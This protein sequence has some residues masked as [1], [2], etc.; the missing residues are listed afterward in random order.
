MNDHAR[1]VLVAEGGNAGR[2]QGERFRRDGI[3][4]EPAGAENAQDVAV[5]EKRNV[6]F[7]GERAF[8]HFTGS[9]RYLADGLSAGHAVAK[10]R[11]SR[12]FPLDL[13]GGQ[14]FVRAIVPFRQPRVRLRHPAETSQFTRLRCALQRTREHQCERMSGEEPAHRD[15]ALNAIRSQRN[16][17]ASGM[18][19]GDAPF[20]FAVADQPDFAR[21][22]IYLRADVPLN[23]NSSPSDMIGGMTDYRTR[24]AGP[25]DLDLICHHRERMFREARSAE[26][27]LAPMTAHFRL[28]LEPRL[29][30]GSYS[31]WIVEHE[32]KAVAGTGLIVLDWPPHPRHPFASRRGYILN[33]FVEPEHRGRGIA[34]SLMKRAAHEA[35][36]RGIPFL[37][38]HATDAGRPVYEKLGW[39]P[40][41]EMSLSTL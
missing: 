4:P 31:G 29:G 24:P 30:D 1:F 13:A 11:P 36:S 39:R 38:L 19:A 16:V 12:A 25:Q 2:S 40:M 32:G 20:R 10:D 35:H 3:E 9:C 14:P 26:A 23:G 41:P 17:G 21:H 5:S 7:R 37:T 6:T 18:G 28:W 22:P 33:V 8:D 34:T 27:A 15:G